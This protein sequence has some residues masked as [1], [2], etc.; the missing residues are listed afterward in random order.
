MGEYHNY[1]YDIVC[2]K[3]HSL[4]RFYCRVALKRVLKQDL[5]LECLFRLFGQILRSFGLIGQLKFLPDIQMPNFLLQ[6]QLQHW[7]EQVFEVSSEVRPMMK[8]IPLLKCHSLKCPKNR[9]F[10]FCTNWEVSVNDV[11]VF[12]VKQLLCL[13]GQ[14]MAP[15]GVNPIKPFLSSITS[16]MDST[17]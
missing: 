11:Q 7:L 2:T 14:E 15:T 17:S 9:H 8:Q 1:I 4:S 16:K 3:E 5:D 12:P 10:E 6:L 13:S